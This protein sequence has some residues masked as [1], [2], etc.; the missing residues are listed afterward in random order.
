MNHH[1]LKIAECLRKQKKYKR[2]EKINDYEY[3]N[4]LSVNF[5]YLINLFI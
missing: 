4:F 5:I 3:L 1:H 2:I